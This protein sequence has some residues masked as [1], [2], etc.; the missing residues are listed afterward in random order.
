MDTMQTTGESE[1]H[2][3]IIW[4]EA[5]GVEDDIVRD[6]GSMFTIVEDL[7]VT[8]SAEQ[9]ADNLTRFYGTSLPAGSY[10]E[11]HVGTGPFRLLIV[12]DASPAYSTVETSKGPKS[13]NSRVF[14]AKT[15]YREMTGGGH[16]IHSTNTPLEFEHD[17]TLL[18]GKNTADYRAG[19]STAF[20]LDSS[21]GTVSGDLTGSGGWQSLRHLFYVLDATVPYVVMRNFEPLPDNFYLE[22]H[23]DIDLL[24]S[25]YEEAA[26]VTGATKV[27]DEPH[28]VHV[29]LQIAGEPVLFDFRF[30]GDAYYDT[31]W[32]QHILQ[33]SVVE[34]GAMNVPSDDDHFYSLLYHALIHKR[35]IAKDYVVAFA[36]LA[37]RPIVVDGVLDEQRAATML[38]RWLAKMNYSLTVAEPSVYY[39]NAMAEL[40]RRGMWRQRPL[41]FGARYLRRRLAPTR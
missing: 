21:S 30:V 22:E 14:D 11:V 25:D 26:W 18:L 39:N 6:L 15:R 5:R 4:S 23:G 37:P 31:A 1:L 36:R 29:S 35:E 12:E 3:F 33:H 40:V 34:R 17:V 32:Q 16:K 24:V 19:R 2:L 10:K 7:E 20:S 13:V 8:W 28:R 38:G 41:R 9:F 27:F